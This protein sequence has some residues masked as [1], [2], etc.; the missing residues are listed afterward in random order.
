MQIYVE[1]ETIWLET[2]FAFMAQKT[3]GALKSIS[4][5]MMCTNIASFFSAGTEQLIVLVNTDN[6]DSSPSNF[7]LLAG[8]A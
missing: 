7:I 1:F 3:G 4:T 6:I 2:S 8:C 5:E